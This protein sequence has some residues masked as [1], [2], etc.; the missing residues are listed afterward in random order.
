MNKLTIIDAM[1]DIGVMAHNLERDRRLALRVA[2]AHGFRYVHTGALPEDWLSGPD[3]EAYISA[4]R[5]SGVLLST[6]FVG[7]NGQSYADRETIARTVGLVRGTFRAHRL[8]IALQYCDLAHALGVPSLAAHVGFIPEDTSH[9]DY[10]P[11]IGTMR[12]ILDRCAA[13][14]QSFHLE[15]GQEPADV[16]LRFLHDVDRP[17]LGVNFD[18]A[19]LLL[20]DTDDPLQALGRLAPF[21][22]GVHCK[23]GLRPREPGQLGTEVP[24]GQGQVNFPA[25]LRQLIAIGYRGLLVIEREHGPQVLEDV[26][27]ARDYLRGLVAELA[28]SAHREGGVVL[29]GCERPAPGS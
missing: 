17:N 2:A 4:V 5:S 13:Y 19:N 9:P 10:A 7:F 23:D 27:A 29:G 20:Y 14:G 24:I 15:T 21:V 18:P 28:G 22:R 8:S 12:T 26:L 25:F 1:L 16:L 3:R 11:L 6:M